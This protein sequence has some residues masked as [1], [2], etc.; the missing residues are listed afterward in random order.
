MTR[1]TNARR[2]ILATAVLMPLLASCGGGDGSGESDTAPSSQASSSPLRI[3]ATIDVPAAG[4]VLPTDDRLW[5][6]SGGATVV[7]QIDPASNAVTE[8]VTIP[9]P[10]AYGTIANGS[11]W[12]VSYGDNAL[13]ELNAR[14]GKLLRTLEGSPTLLNPSKNP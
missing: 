9:H 6:I 4:V 7:T 14:T 12:L 2:V 8:R 1:G 3:G 13:M 5:V 11:L 10:A